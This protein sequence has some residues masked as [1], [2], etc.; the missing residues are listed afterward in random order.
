[1]PNGIS[2]IAVTAVMIAI[3]GAIRY[4]EPTDVF[5]RNG[6]FIA[7]LTISAIGCSSPN[8]PTRF[9]P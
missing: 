3:S 1:L 2:A 7:N 9:G 4:R 8:G 6:S 5:V